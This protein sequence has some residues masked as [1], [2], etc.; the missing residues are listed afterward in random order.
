MKAA[1]DAKTRKTWVKMAAGGWMMRGYSKQ[2]AIDALCKSGDDDRT[3]NTAAAAEDE[4]VR[5]SSI[6][7]FTFSQ[8]ATQVFEGDECRAVVLMR[9]ASIHS[10]IH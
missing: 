9:D 6:P 4:G 8:L 3:T 2:R 10:H 1:L 5:K 7:F